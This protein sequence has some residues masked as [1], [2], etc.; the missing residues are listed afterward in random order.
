MNA[1]RPMI[2]LP[3][4]SFAR[5]D[6]GEPDIVRRFLAWAQCADEETRA[7]GVSALAR[8]YLYSDL[9]APVR[10][11]AVLAMTALAD[12]ASVLVRRALAE[13]LCSA[14]EAPRPLI[15]ALAGDEPEVAASILQRSPALTDADLVECAATDD[16]IAQT[17]LARRPDLPPGAI[18]ILAETGELD[19]VLALIGN[20]EIDI[21]AETLSRVFARFGGNP[22]MREA[23][24]DRP[25]LPAGL[26]VR[27][28]IVLAKD[29]AVEAARWMPLKR[30]ERIAHVARDQAICSI[31]SSCRPEEHAE[32]MRVL[33]SAG[34]LT[35]ALLLRSLL[36]GERDLFAEALADL[37]GLPPLRVSA[38]ICEPRGEGFAA[39]A[40]K[41]GLKSGVLPA[42]RAALAAI[43]SHVGVAG[44][45]LK[46]G[47]VQK[48]ID[49]CERRADPK[50]AKVLALLWR[51][52]AEA[53][54]AEAA[55]FAR[56]AAASASAGRLPHILDFSPVNDDGEAPLL[57]A[58]FDW[59]PT[60][61]APPLE[62]RPP[63]ANSSEDQ[64]PPVELPPEAVAPFDHAA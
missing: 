61:L 27:M 57:I 30:A 19:A 38:F 4:L 24:L 52:A 36:S 12:D 2:E 56:E 60:A 47:L 54:R 15:L 42:F 33:R 51:F 31:A 14:S 44:E 49:E 11:E 7:Q 43:K 22:N 50:L 8:A 35:P 29:L 20:L 55:S 48:V 32:L 45:G 34:A 23:L 5:P 21:P 16:L 26:R 18:A 9:A 41:A 25:T 58:D 59:P 64:A 3:P 13:A 37:S 62:L 17:A 10:G 40:H 6:L 39:L 1:N 63:E 53:A 28:V 46:L